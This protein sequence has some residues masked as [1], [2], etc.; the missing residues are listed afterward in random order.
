MCHINMHAYACASDIYMRVWYVFVFVCVNLCLCVVI[1]VGGGRITPRYAKQT[2]HT[3]LWMSKVGEHLLQALVA[4]TCCRHLLQ[5][6]VRPTL[7]LNPLERQRTLS[8]ATLPTTKA[9]HTKIRKRPSLGPRHMGHELKAALH[10]SHTHR[11]LTP[12]TPPPNT[13]E[14]A[15]IKAKQRCVSQKCRCL[16]S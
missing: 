16:A 1:H 15:D 7:Y 12:P 5:A 9:H 14:H 6:L 3:S 13:H 4:G 11:C 10:S 2:R 8:S